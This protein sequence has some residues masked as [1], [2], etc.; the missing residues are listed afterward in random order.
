MK[1]KICLVTPGHIASNPRIV[2]EADA[3]YQDGY[4]VTVIYTETT[5]EIK[6]LDNEILKVSGWKYEKVILG[7]KIIRGSRKLLNKLSKTITEHYIPNL[8]YAALSQNPYYFILN[9]TVIKN[10][11]DL[12][13]GH[14]LPALPVVYNA[15][16]TNSAIFGFDAEDFHSGEEIE[17]KELLLR[18]FLE[19][20]LL[21]KAE[22]LT[23]SSP[24]I[25][26]LYNKE[27]NVFMETLL[28]V[29]P[30]NY[31]QNL[32]NQKK[33]S[34]SIYWFS[35]TIGPG[36]GLEEILK[37]ISLTKTKP[38]LFLRGSTKVD[39]EF[40]RNLRELSVEYGLKH[41]L[42][43]LETSSPDSM[44]SCAA[45]YDMG[46]SSELNQP[47]NRSACLTNKIFTYL[48]AGIPVILSKTHAQHQIY[49]KIKDAALMIDLENE[50]QSAEI[51]DEILGNKDK[52]NLMKTAAAEL[53]KNKYNWNIE[54]EKFL[55]IIE[56]TLR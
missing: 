28:N 23:C 7:N 12:Y 6:K 25:S 24:N 36:R 48:L 39:E 1:K 19:S 31:A 9:S 45:Q 40:I 32:D 55:K 15:A 30:L 5:H 11:A 2:K 42:H 35:Q 51:I 8:T 47:L 43:F 52:L 16:K 17:G 53:A 34:N 26:D 3:L 21:C 4:D 20:K 27:Y 49:S 46:I 13:I 38:S 22:Y 50:S 18:K 37:I 33:Y 29:F 14:N 54:K 10:K 41:K 44:V 56:N